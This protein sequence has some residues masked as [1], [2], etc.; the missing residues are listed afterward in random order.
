MKELLE[1]IRNARETRDFEY[2]VGENSFLITV[3]R[4]LP[5]TAARKQKTALIKLH[6]VIQVE[7]QLLS[8]MT[9]EEFEQGMATQ[10]DRTAL[11]N[12][13]FCEC[14]ID[15]ETGET[16]LTVEE[17]VELFSVNFKIEVT[18]WAMG[19][20]APLDEDNLSEE[21]EFPSVSDGSESRE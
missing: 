6:Q 9:P 16:Y 15:K 19:G 13:D 8:E 5:G 20:A 2:Q 7:A 17:A 14:V 4:F 1:Q 18:D 3:K 21:E 12:A 10:E 11:L